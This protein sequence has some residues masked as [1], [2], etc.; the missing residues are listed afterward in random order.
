MIDCGCHASFA[1]F[2]T[3]ISRSRSHPSYVSIT[4]EK[5][6]SVPNMQTHKTQRGILSFIF[7]PMLQF[8]SRI[9]K[10]LCL[11]KELN[12][13]SPSSID[14]LP[15]M[16]PSPPLPRPCGLLP[17]PR[18]YLDLRPSILPSTSNLYVIFVTAVEFVPSSR[19][20]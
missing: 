3:S 11:K 15:I 8:V 4:L 1:Y 12:R 17:P 10:N 20:I 19:F 16:Q 7:T 9:K 14:T 18:R 6:Y 13:L 5:K 2:I